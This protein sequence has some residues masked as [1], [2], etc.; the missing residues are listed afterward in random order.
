M[1]I[2]NANIDLHVHPFLDNYGIHHVLEAMDANG[3]HGIG[4]CTLDAT[5]FPQ[6]KLMLE[7]GGYKFV[8]DP[9]GLIVDG[10]SLWNTREYNT[11]ESLHVLTIGHSYDDATPDTEIRR[12]IDEGLEQD[13]L[14]GLD[15]IYVDNLTT[16]TAG[17]ISDS[18]EQQ[19]IDICKEFNGEIFLEWNGYC[20][21]NLRKGLQIL[22]NL[23][24]ANI[25]YYDVNEKVL[26]LSERLAQEG[27]HIPVIA[28]TDLHA[29]TV[30]LLN[31]MGAA[32]FITDVE[33]ET[34][35]EVLQSIKSN[36]FAGQYKNK[37]NYV[38]IPHFFSAFG[39]PV[40][41][42]HFVPEPLKK[43]FPQPRA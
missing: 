41:M 30:G 6:L 28:D 8:S 34:P 24:G 1:S 11:R 21:P 43:Y 42:N 17:H 36:I 18:A 19:V 12:V 3:L 22:M 38:S 2:E 37:L 7:T 4:P 31:D 9:S 26:E 5:L 16:L 39:V 25:K 20:K 40:V 23:F 13:A 33:G 32:R 15:H 27:V 14:V 29:R 35:S 10:K